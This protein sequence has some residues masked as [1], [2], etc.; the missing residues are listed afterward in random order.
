M[1]DLYRAIDPVLLGPDEE[2]PNQLSGGWS[3]RK[4]F[5]DV[6]LRALCDGPA[7]RVLEPTLIHQMKTEWSS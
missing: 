2:G 1:S 4:V 3:R 7:V 6:L 5:V